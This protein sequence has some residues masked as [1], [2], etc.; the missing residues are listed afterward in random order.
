MR[1]GPLVGAVAA[2]LRPVPAARARTFAALAV[3]WH[4]DRGRPRDALRLA[5]VAGD[6]GRCADLVRHHGGAL[7]AAGAAEEVVATVAALPP[8]LRDAAVD[9]AHADALQ[10][11]GRTDAATAV[12]A[13]LA[14]GSAELPAG[15]AWRYGSA[16]YLWG[17]PRDALAVLRRGKRAPGAD[18]DTAL[19]LAWTAAAHWLAGEE[20]E[21]AA[22]AAEA[23]TAARATG[24]QRALAAAHVA[25]AL[26]AHLTGDPVGL[27][28]HYGRALESAEAAGDTVQ[29]VRVRVNLAA[30]L[31]QEGR[32][33]DALAV[34]DPAVDAARSSGYDSSLALALANQGSLLHRTGRIDD[35]VAA[36]REAVR[37]YERMHSMKVA[38]PLTG[39]GDI[40]RSRGQPAQARAAYTEALNAAVRDGNNRQGMVPALCGLARV[41]ADADPAGAA[42]LADQAVE[43]AQGHW[44]ATALVTRAWVAR[45]AGNGSAARRDARA[46][47]E[48][49][50]VHRD[51]GGLAHA[52]EV[53]AATTDDPAAARE[54]LRE[55]LSI[56]DESGAVL[57]ADRVRVALGECA[58]GDDDVRLEGRLAASRLA[59]AG[60]VEALPARPGAPGRVEVRVLGEFAVLVDGQPL[61]PRAWQSRK[62][63]DLLRVLVARRGSRC[64]ARSWPTCSG[65]RCPRPTGR[66]WRTGSRNSM[67]KIRSTLIGVAALL[68]LAG[69]PAAASAEGRTAGEHAAAGQA[70]ALSTCVPGVWTQVHWYVT[71]FWVANYRYT[72]APGV[73]VKWRWFSGGVPPYWEGSFT[74]SG[75]IWTPPSWY[76]SVEFMCSSPTSVV[77]RPL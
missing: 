5:A 27:R 56:W 49:A 45:L 37:V 39:L 6:S 59:A 53:E 3:D 41:V 76:T 55:T 2:V 67:T 22:L 44:A 31:E 17:D 23:H 7:L 43:H 71:P 36:Y 11:T 18:A 12:Y 14:E 66:R 19:L 1:A 61:P 35:A 69:Q 73:F 9:L 15:L 13:R 47:A 54:L 52:L 29:V 65:A 50:A 51:R 63:R 20:A 16:V 24:D 60:V 30:G 48:V 8:A 77:I 34:L 42:D 58:G 26:C 68:A 64:P 33:A 72:V 74:T 32:L 70:S 25:L 62:A 57:D 10:A 75:D 4:R 40:H 46:A 21:C 38:Y 28:A